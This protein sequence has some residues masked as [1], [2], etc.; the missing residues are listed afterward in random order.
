MNAKKVI[1]VLSGFALVGALTMSTS[2]QAF[3]NG[4]HMSGKPSGGISNGK[5]VIKPG[6]MAKHDS[7]R[8]HHHRDHRDFWYDSL[9]YYSAD[10]YDVSSFSPCHLEKRLTRGGNPYYVQFCPVG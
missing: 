6:V 10:P 5:Q 8:H 9:F 7:H 3:T 2:A 4:P 1:A